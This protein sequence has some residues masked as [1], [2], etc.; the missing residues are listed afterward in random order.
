M[1]EPELDGGL[2]M[3]DRATLP[4]IVLAMHSSSTWTPS[5]TASSLIHKGGHIF[6]RTHVEKIEG[7]HPA[8][9]KT[10]GGFVITADAVVVATNTPIMNI[11][12]RV[13]VKEAGKDPFTKK[14]RLAAKAFEAELKRLMG[15]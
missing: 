9:I 6:T 13:V 3:V 7:G 5:A 14:D 8:R 4:H 2:C 10:R 15:K 1:K 11:D 12:Y